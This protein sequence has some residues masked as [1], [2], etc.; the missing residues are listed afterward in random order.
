MLREKGNAGFKDL[1]K[2]Y[3]KGFELRGKTLGVIGFG[4]IGQE[5][6][7]IAIGLGMKVKAFNRTPGNFELT[8]DHLPFQPTPK[9]TIKSVSIDEVC[10]DSDF[11]SLHVPHSSGQPALIDPPR[12]ASMKKGIVIINCARGGVIDEKALM[13]GLSSGQIG[14]AA[15]DVFENEPN[16]NEILLGSDK[17]SLTPHIGA[18]TR[19]AQERVSQEVAQ[20]IIDK[21]GKK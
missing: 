9:L 14:A 11:I 17:I 13:D 16:F 15:L 10:K 2:E 4:R 8:F 6:A 1:K 12:I 5:T 21:F 3:E 7:K 18:S 19:E 20:V